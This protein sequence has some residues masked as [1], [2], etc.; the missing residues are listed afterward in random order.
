MFFT[1]PVGIV[2][3]TVPNTRTDADQNDYRG[4]SHQ[5]FR[6]SWN[7]CVDEYGDF[8]WNVIDSLNK[9]VRLRCDKLHTNVIEIV[10]WSTFPTP[11]FS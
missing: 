4:I 7:F 2:T 3:T 8:R 5:Y 6:Q 1:Y 11:S 10:L 9:G